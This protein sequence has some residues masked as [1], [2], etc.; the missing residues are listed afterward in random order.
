MSSTQSDTVRGLVLFPLD[1]PNRQP[2]TEIPSEIKRENEATFRGVPLRVKD[3]SLSIW[4][5][6]R[7]R[8][9][10]TELKS[11]VLLL[12]MNIYC[13]GLPVDVTMCGKKKT[14]CLSGCIDNGLDKCSHILCL[15]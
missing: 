15:D 11:H 2:D 7:L 13:L 4:E 1:P 14:L 5:W 8:L 10:G 6:K 9:L 12:L 3:I